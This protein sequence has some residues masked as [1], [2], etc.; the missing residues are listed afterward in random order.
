[1]KKVSIIVPVYNVEKYL[2]KCLDSLV[3]QTFKDIEILVI[4]DG[5]PDNSQTIIDV[6]QKKY[7]TLI[8]SFIKENGGLASARNLGLENAHGSYVVF[9][10]SDDWVDKQM[11]EKLYNKVTETDSDITVCGAYGVIDGENHLL[12]TFKQYSSDMNKNYIISCA[13]ACWQIIKREIFVSHNLHFLENHYY[14]DIAIIPS[15]G[16]FANKISYLNDNLY[17]YLMR[18]GSIM[19]RQQYSKKLEDIFDSMEHLSQIYKKENEYDKY[20]MELEYLY[21]EHLLHAA[22]LRFFEFDKY[23]QL[24]KIVKIIK[25]QYPNWKKNKYYKMQNI[26]Y[27]IVCSLFYKKRY[28]LL[29]IILKR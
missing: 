11:I 12:E 3:N 18:S 16:L 7:P 23:D 27:K 24:S 21:I 15:L 6:Y 28:K 8:T 1:M 29:K 25:E 14:E 4:N 17:Y 22:S 5:S 10:D 19:R 9:V 13:G 2:A 20:Y 26:K